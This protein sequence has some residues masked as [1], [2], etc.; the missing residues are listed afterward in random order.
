MV[1]ESCSPGPRAWAFGKQAVP[2]QGCPPW[3]T[4]KL[5][6]LSV[7]SVGSTSHRAALPRGEAWR[8]RG[9]GQLGA[10]SADDL[11]SRVPAPRALSLHLAPGHVLAPG[12]GVGYTFCN[13]EKARWVDL[14]L[15]PVPLLSVLLLASTP[16]GPTP[17][18][19]T[20]VFRFP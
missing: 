2:E 14:F 3:V 4:S 7:E 1:E 8:R 11:G 10:V 13:P 9:A 16:D 17:L 18:L 15:H 19:F 5:C 20:P 6:E 12:A